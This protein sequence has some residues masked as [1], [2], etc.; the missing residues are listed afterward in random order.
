MRPHFLMTRDEAYKLLTKYLKNKNLLKHSF[1]AEASMKGLY[2]RLLPADE[3]TPEDEEKWGIVGLLHDVDYE[4]A[5]ETNQ[6]DKHGLLIF[7]KEPNAFP[8]D[9][10][11]AIKSHNFQN[12][13]VMPESL[14]DW[15]ITACDQLTGLIVAAAL[16]HPEKK[17]AP[18]TP[19]FILNRMKEKSFARGA[20]RD[21]IMLCEEK[22]GIELPVFVEIVLSAMKSIH[23]ELGL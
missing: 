22:L 8:E 21:A 18:L 9:I 17:L 13:K 4:L 5:Q 12:T 6:L 20:D 19:E 2:K 15:S 7:E 11:H 1:A 23:D 10:A 14:M 3:Q 16:V